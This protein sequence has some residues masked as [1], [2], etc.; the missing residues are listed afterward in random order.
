[1]T[2]RDRSPGALDYPPQDSESGD[3][4]IDLEISKRVIS[5][6]QPRRKKS[7]AMDLVRERND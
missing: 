3:Q 2:D 6:I 4:Q 5:R 7:S 1:M